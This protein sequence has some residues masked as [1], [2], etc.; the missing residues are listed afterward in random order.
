[1]AKTTIKEL[2]TRI[3]NM[4]NTLSEIVKTL[5]S[6][7]ESVNGKTSTPK[8]K[9]TKTTTKTKV[10]KDATKCEVTV[11]DGQGRGQGKKFINIVFDGKPTDK[12]LK[13]LKD[14]GFKYF[15]P[16][17]VWSTLHTDGK[18]KFAESLTK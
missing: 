12:T 10:S 7:N 13:S 18:M 4:E 8:S 17:K 14:N 16:T 2:E 5:N 15:A 9:A 6:I 11:V 1:M 3:D